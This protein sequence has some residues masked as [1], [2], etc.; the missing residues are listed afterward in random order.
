[1]SQASASESTALYL[2]D[3]NVLITAHRDYYP[4]TR[5][6]EFW[7]WLEHHAAGGRVKIPVE[8]LDEVGRGRKRQGPDELLD[9]L[10]DDRVR[11][12]L[13]LDEQPDPSHVRRVVAEGY[14]PDLTEAELVKL[15]RDPFLIAYALADPTRR[16]I[17]T[18]VSLSARKETCEPEDPRCGRTVRDH[19]P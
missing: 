17:V 9:W 12:M 6:P 1:M 16:R 13:V 2:L 15:G 18:T 10:G 19:G 3:A 5:V 7:T 8:M 11:D 14:A 4:V